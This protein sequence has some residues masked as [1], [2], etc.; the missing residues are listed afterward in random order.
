LFNFIVR[1]H[2]G[3]SKHY[4][5][6]LLTGSKPLASSPLENLQPIGTKIVGRPEF[7][8]PYNS[9]DQEM[10][11]SLEHKLFGQERHANLPP[12]LWG[13]DQTLNCQSDSSLKAEA[14]FPDGRSTNPNEAFNEN[15]LFSSSLSDFFD[16]KCESLCSNTCNNSISLSHQRIQYSL[17]RDCNKLYHLM[18]YLLPSISF[19]G[20][21]WL[22]H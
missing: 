16:K 10:A 19:D 15:G 2:D 18:T 1:H 9:R 7:V 22:R 12:S 5:F 6:P 4:L 17:V 20:T 13:A 14:L 8:Q 3:F 21:I 11:F